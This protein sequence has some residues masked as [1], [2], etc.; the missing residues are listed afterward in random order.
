MKKIILV[1]LIMSFALSTVFLP[2]KKLPTYQATVLSEYDPTFF[3]GC[4]LGCALSWDITASS[5]LKP[6]EKNSYKP[7]NI[8]DAGHLHLLVRGC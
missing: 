2:Q 1:A 7:D 3:P 4:S 6:Q 5:V 8:S